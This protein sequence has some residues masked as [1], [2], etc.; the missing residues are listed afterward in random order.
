MSALR[1]ELE[2]VQVQLKLLDPEVTRRQLAL[3]ADQLEREAQTWEQR[4]VQAE[5]RATR[6]TQSTAARVTAFGFALL[7]VTPIVA[8]I[9][10]AAARSLRGQGELAVA[11]LVGGLAL[12]SAVSLGRVRRRIARVFSRE[13]RLVRRTR[14]E[15]EVISS[16]APE[17][18]D[19]PRTTSRQIGR[20]HV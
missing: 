14:H 1:D 3:L 6:E 20:A 13:W 11:L 17:E 15:M 18:V 9:G 19:T 7:F 16:Y 12:I 5:A 8:I 2:Q 4:L 10:T